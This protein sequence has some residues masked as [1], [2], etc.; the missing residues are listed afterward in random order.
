[1]AERSMRGRRF[2][3]YLSRLTRSRQVWDL[4]ALY[5]EGQQ[6]LAVS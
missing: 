6:L 5:P 1:M 2:V 3:K 4:P